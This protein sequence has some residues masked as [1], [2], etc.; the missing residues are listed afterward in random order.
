M[1]G[2]NVPRALR[3]AVTAA[4]LVV[5]H[6]VAYAA[7]SGARAFGAWRLACSQS[8]ANDCFIWQSITADRAPKQAVLG[9]SVRIPKSAAVPEMQFRITPDADP[10]AGVGVKI[11]GHPDYRLAIGVCDARLCQATGR[12]Q[13]AV[14]TQLLAGKLAQ[15]AFRASGDQHTVVVRLDGFEPALKELERRR[16]RGG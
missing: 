11:D 7:D 12:V 13:G 16:S 5:A 9:V 15:V 1:P 3:A 2:V 14:R 6:T 8:N 4:A 10:T